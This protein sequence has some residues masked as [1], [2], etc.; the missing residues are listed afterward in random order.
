MWV[1]KN[2]YLNINKLIMINLLS[3]LKVWKF[4]LKLNVLIFTESD[5]FYKSMNLTG[6]PVPQGLQ[7]SGVPYQIGQTLTWLE[8]LWNF[9]ETNR[10]KYQ[11]FMTGKEKQGKGWPAL[12][13]LCS[14]PSGSI[15]QSL[16]CVGSSTRKVKFWAR[17]LPCC[18]KSTALLAV[19]WSFVALL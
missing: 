5:F 19:C 1:N 3:I 15:L 14:P 6:L 9:C 16:V 10:W 11:S 4:N 12:P 13:G 8:H 17:E 2:R 18:Q 7:V